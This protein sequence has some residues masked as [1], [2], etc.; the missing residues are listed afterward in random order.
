MHAAVSPY[1]DTPEQRESLKQEFSQSYLASALRHIRQD[2]AS[3][4]I[5]QTPQPSKVYVAQEDTSPRYL[6]LLEWH[7]GKIAGSAGGHLEGDRYPR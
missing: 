2:S 4:A 6:G 3:F 1:L 5:P 7:C